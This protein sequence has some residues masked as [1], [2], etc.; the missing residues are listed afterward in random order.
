MLCDNLC[1]LVQ[2][3]K[4]ERRHKGQD[5][6]T[7]LSEAG[8]NLIFYFCRSDLCNYFKSRSVLALLFPVFLS[9]VIPVERRDAA[10]LV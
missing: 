4:G 8:A 3:R 5:N 2:G 1:S 9:D 7:Q 6:N 10:C